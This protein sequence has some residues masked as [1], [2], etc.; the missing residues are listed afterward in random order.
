[1]ARSSSTTAT[2]TGVAALSNTYPRPWFG[3]LTETAGIWQL[4]PWGGYDTAIPGSGLDYECTTRYRSSGGSLVRTPVINSSNDVLCSCAAVV[5]RPTQSPALNA[6]DE[7]MRP[8]CQATAV[9]TPRPLMNGYWMDFMITFLPNG[10]ARGVAFFNRRYLFSFATNEA[11]PKDSVKG[12]LPSN[13]HFH[14]R[15][16]GIVVFERAV[17][18]GTTITVAKDSLPQHDDGI[19]ASPQQALSSMLPMRRVIVSDQ[20]GGIRVLKPFAT[21][22]KWLEEQESDVDPAQR[23]WTS[24]WEFCDASD[25]DPQKIRV[26]GALMEEFLQQHNPYP[27]IKPKP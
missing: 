20:T 1:M 3:Y 13:T 16:D 14:G 4:H 22:S 11:S 26:S 10:Q 19:F 17:L 2:R 6:L 23:I 9:G 5:G 7:E 18:G 15:D 27:W 25:P 8:C 12:G 24:G 21:I